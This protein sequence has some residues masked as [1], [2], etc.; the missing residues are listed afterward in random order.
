ME[1]N[2]KKLL[3]L[4]DTKNSWGKEQLKKAILEML[5]E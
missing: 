1:I 5:A 4:I 2:L 3:E